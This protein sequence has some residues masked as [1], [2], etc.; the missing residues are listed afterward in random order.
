M[1]SKAFL[2]A[3]FLLVI[4]A[5]SAFAQEGDYAERKALAEKLATVNPVARMMESA[6][7]RVASEWGL[8]EKEKFQREM[9]D[10]LDIAGVEKTSVQAMAD[11]FTKEEL[12]VMLAYYSAPEARK[13]AEK[14]PVYQGLI[15][16]AIA[17]EMD[18]V[19]MKLRT[20]YEAQMK[21]AAPPPAT[22]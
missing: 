13:I 16:P 11:T 3:G 1:F 19:L 20:G 18:R 4:A 5:G 7:L 12:E 2:T 22:P 10:N 17:R 14:M 15:Q 6:V 8:S 21:G 9:M